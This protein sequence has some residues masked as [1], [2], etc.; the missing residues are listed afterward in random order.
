[1]RAQAVGGDGAPD[2][3]DRGHGWLS[4]SESIHE[5][6]QGYDLTVTPGAYREATKVIVATLERIAN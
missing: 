3:R 6:V 2:K 1:V 5:D 4:E